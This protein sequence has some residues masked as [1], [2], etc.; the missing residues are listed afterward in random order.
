VGKVLH[1]F[2]QFHEESLKTRE[3]EGRKEK[4][5]YREEEIKISVFIVF[6]LGVDALLCF[7]LGS[8]HLVYVGYACPSFNSGLLLSIVSWLFN[9]E[10]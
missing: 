8:F 10:G 5:K 9:M 2:C 4:S 6:L 3:V 7:N 1:T